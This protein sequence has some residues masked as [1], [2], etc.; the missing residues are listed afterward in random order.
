MCLTDIYVYPINT[1]ISGL[2]VRGW[3][4]DMFPQHSINNQAQQ[5]MN[6]AL[7]LQLL[8]RKGLCSRAELA[9][10]SG[11]NRATVSNII[12]DFIRIGLVEEEGALEGEL[13]RRAV[14]ICIDSSR[15]QVL[16]VM[17][18]RTRY[19]LALMALSGELCGTETY[20][21]PRSSS[22]TM[23]IDEMRGRIR[24]M[25]AQTSARV[26]SIGIALPGPY[27]TENGEL[28]F[29]TNLPGWDAVPIYSILQE[30]SNIPIFL[31][32]DANAGALAQLWFRDR[33][34]ERGDMVYVVAGQGIGCGIFS[35]GRLIK[36]DLGIAGEIGHTTICYDGPRCEC[37]NRGC[38][39]LYCSAL[40]LKKRILDLIAQGRAPYLGGTISWGPLTAAIR[41]KR[42][43]VYEEYVR[44]CEFL[45]VGI[46]NLVHQIDPHTIII[47]DLLA[48][49]APEIMQS[50]VCRK[51]K[52]L[53]RPSV[54]QGLHI[55]VSRLSHNPGLL[56]ACVV[57][58]MEV[59]ED[60]S[61]YMDL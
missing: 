33:A 56:G 42:S 23:V 51:V 34:E 38:L 26:L 27:Q 55:E 54:W 59:M 10:L 61:A 48:D 49:L 46:V 1:Y 11:L 12:S 29:I 15:F 24:Q 16:G 50:T 9:R 45:A 2:L 47:G 6:R 53:V 8:R 60:P 7:L 41:Q 18:T 43:P 30:G 28:I 13:G 5:R 52:E 32:N 4:R 21:I 58:A 37:G 57:A 35:N 39:E 14:G 19:S 22:A 44:A 31:E 20:T 17:I 40:A 25:I 3:Y 36:G